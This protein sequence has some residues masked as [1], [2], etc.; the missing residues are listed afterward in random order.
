[1]KLMKA[2][3]LAG[4]EGAIMIQSVSRFVSVVVAAFIVSAIASSAEAA[5][6]QQ[7]AAACHLNS[8]YF[9]HG[10]TTDALYVFCPVEE[11]SSFR[12]NSVRAL[13]LDFTGSGAW[14]QV[15]TELAGGFGSVCQTAPF[16]S[17][18]GTNWK[19]VSGDTL[20]PWSDPHSTAGFRYFVLVLGT[21]TSFRGYLL[22]HD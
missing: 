6:K 2:F 7:S 17:G 12:V 15:C 1:M 3:A 13:K 16:L 14:V 19:T 9:S 22:E 11:T 8:G 18:S 5:W 10:G 4:R 21:G 20:G